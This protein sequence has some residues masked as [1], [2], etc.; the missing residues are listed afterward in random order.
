[1][2]GAFSRKRR[3]FEEFRGYGAERNIIN[4][5]KTT[6]YSVYI[7]Y[8][9]RQYPSNNTSET[10]NAGACSKLSFLADDTQVPGMRRR[11][12]VSNCDVRTLD[13]AAPG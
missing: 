1:M 13:L 3:Q 11:E 6:V 5:C 2:T 12:V 8:H 7:R 9:I 10:I 4:V